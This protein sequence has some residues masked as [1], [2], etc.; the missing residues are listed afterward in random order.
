MAALAADIEMKF[1][2]RWNP[3]LVQFNASAA[4]TYYRGGLAHLLNDGTGLTLTPADADFYFGVV[5][6]HKVITAA[7]EL[8]WCGTAGRWFFTAAALTLA[9][10]NKAFAIA[11]ATLF[12]N[13]A[14]LNVLAGGDP[15]AVGY[16]YQVG[17]DAQDGWINT[18]HRMAP[19]N[20]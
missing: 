2:P 20:S 9:D 8:V 13:P 1:D 19:T 12:D 16:L 10:M 11:Q 17:T 3:G 14:D 7:T 5:A 15:G 18:D 4:D 6:E